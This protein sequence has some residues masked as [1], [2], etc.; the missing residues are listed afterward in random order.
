[1]KREVKSLLNILIKEVNMEFYLTFHA[2]TS[3]FL[4]AAA[5]VKKTLQS[6]HILL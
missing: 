1:M 4:W 2:Q 3:C 6:Y 5:P